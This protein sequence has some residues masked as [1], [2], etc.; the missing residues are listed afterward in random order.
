M[1]DIEGNSYMTSRFY[2]GYITRIKT[3]NFY[4]S[5][6]CDPN[7]APSWQYERTETETEKDFTDGVWMT[8]NLKTKKLPNGTAI[9]K[10]TANSDTNPQYYPPNNNESNLTSY[11]ALYNWAAAIN[12]GNGAGQTPDPGIVEQGG[13]DKNDVH[14]QG[15]CPTGWHL[16]S[17]QEW[18]D[19]ENGIILKTSLFSSTPS[20][21]GTLLTYDAI[22]TR[23]TLHG[24]AIKS[25][26]AVAG[27]SYGPPNGTS[28]TAAQGGFDAYLAGLANNGSGNHYGN[29]AFFWSAS[30]ANNGSYRLAWNKTLDY[31][32]AT[33]ERGYGVRYFLVSVRCKKD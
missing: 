6:S 19:L 4:R 33:L 16:P 15:I 7:M 27:N 18:T 14:I 9:P 3:Y 10:H 31:N 22:G 21:G 24:Q 20:I 11:G 28:K 32:R 26:T 17:D 30:S 5:Y 8:Q 1:T 13:G 2:V 23:G 29:F 12:M 25:I